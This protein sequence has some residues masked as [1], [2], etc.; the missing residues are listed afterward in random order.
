MQV[1]KNKINEFVF[2]D[3]G[4][5][6]SLK[7]V[8]QLWK[9]VLNRKEKQEKQKSECRYTSHKRCHYAAKWLSSLTTAVKRNNKIENINRRKV[10][11][12]P[13][14]TAYMHRFQHRYAHFAC[15][16]EAKCMKREDSTQVWHKRDT[17]TAQTPHKCGASG[18]LVWSKI[19]VWNQNFRLIFQLYFL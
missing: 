9:Q 6:I 8:Y 7:T 4:Q 1:K 17:C 10:A 2:Y 19:R 3:K 13:V 16:K 5:P 11:K 12:E 14:Y 18:T 15:P